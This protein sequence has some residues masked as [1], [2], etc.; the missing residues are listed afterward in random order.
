MRNL[1][2]SGIGF[3]DSAPSYM[4]PHAVPSGGDW[5]LERTAALFFEGTESLVVRQ[6]RAK[7]R[8]YS[9]PHPDPLFC[10]PQVRNCT[11]SRAGGNGL[12]L[13]GYARD[14]TLADNVFRFA[15]EILWVDSRF[16]PS[17]PLPSLVL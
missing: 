8:C 3:K 7:N 14:A 13:S 10:R 16:A 11:V 4:E 9:C 5:A 12:M 2:I 1:T 17:R 6:G 15:A